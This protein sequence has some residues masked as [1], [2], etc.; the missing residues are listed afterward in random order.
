MK[1]IE[2][3]DFRCFK[4]LNL[5]LKS[6]I[7]LLVGDNASG[8]TSILRACQYALASFFSGFSDANTTLIGP[9]LQDFRCEYTPEN[10]LI[11]KKP[12]QIN[13]SFFDSDFEFQGN[14]Y[15]QVF[16]VSKKSEKNSKQATKGFSLYKKYSHE[17]FANYWDSEMHQRRYALPLFV[18]FT[19]EDIHSKRKVSSEKF[20]DNTPAH[21][22][23][24][25]ECF[26][27]NGF[28]RYWKKRLLILKETDQPSVEL[29]VWKTAIIDAL[30]ENGCRIVKDITIR[31][32]AKKILLT[33][34]DGRIVDVE[35][36]SDG[37]K[38]LL[39]IVTEIALRSAI[40]NGDI[41]GDDSARKTH[42][43]VLIDEIDMHLHPSL[44]ARV[45]TSLSNAF[46][47]IQIIATTHAPIIMSGVKNSD[48]NAVYKISYSQNDKSYSVSAPQTY[49]RDA[50]QIIEDILEQ[51][52]RD[53][54]IAQ[55]LQTLFQKIDNEQIDEAEDFIQNHPEL[56]SLPDIQR[57]KTMIEFY[58][59]GE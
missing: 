46:P 52:S 36:L 51:P 37:H 27:C 39:S 38:R 7:N 19:T 28:F 29:N 24:Y 33:L 40:L 6:G 42:G 14:H 17:L 44:Q 50:T 18:S 59:M 15:G 9:C 20:H 47:L 45:L 54:E 8:K 21:S 58:K 13:F 41:Y 30:G 4:S 16:C 35:T 31:I 32:N 55:S 25:Y 2:I 43:T 1:S 53:L 22:L 48:K 12:I 10:Y 11:P 3:I 49:G 56:D 34:L 57:A 26:N 5:E 23:G